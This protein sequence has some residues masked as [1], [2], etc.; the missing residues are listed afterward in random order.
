M[1]EA[2]VAAGLVVERGSRRRGRAPGA[3]R[4]GG[5]SARRGCA[6][7]RGRSP[8]CRPRRP[9]AVVR[10][11][12]QGAL[13]QGR[14]GRA[15][16]RPR[17]ARCPP[18]WRC[19]RCRGCCCRARSGG[20]RTPRR[21]SPS[22]TPGIRAASPRKGERAVWAWIG[23]DQV[24]RL[25]DRVDVAPGTSGNCRASAQAGQ[26]LPRVHGGTLRGRTHVRSGT[27]PEPGASDVPEPHGGGGQLR[28][29]RA[30][31][32]CAATTRAPATRTMSLNTY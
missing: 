17:G 14:A 24:Q 10:R 6:T 15:G 23:P 4:R 11:E 25:G 5:R 2:E 1:A 8:R 21:W 18:G 12:L 22:V 7:R 26:V 29:S 13:P 3:S 31:R 20:R 28:R 27:S 19:A 9:R 30:P 32:A 16:S